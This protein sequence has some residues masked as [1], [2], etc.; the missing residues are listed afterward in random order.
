MPQV[1]ELGSEVYHT[2]FDGLGPVK[3]YV[4]TLG[5]RGVYSI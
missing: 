1:L 4:D 5:G 3:G 2:G